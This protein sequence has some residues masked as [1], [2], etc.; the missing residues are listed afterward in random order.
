MHSDKLPKGE[1]L[2]FLS[3]NVIKFELQK[4]VAKNN[5]DC[6]K[7]D[8]KLFLTGIKN[9]GRECFYFYFI[10]LWKILTGDRR[11]HSFTKGKIIRI[12]HIMGIFLNENF[13]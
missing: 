6:A 9:I 12:P 4:T 8:D 10:L 3:N 2:P 13:I 1:N 5:R 11:N 7:K